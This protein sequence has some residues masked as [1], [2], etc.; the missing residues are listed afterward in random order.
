M[1]RSPLSTKRLGRG[2]WKVIR[3]WGRVR[4]EVGGGWRPHHPGPRR[5][6]AELN[7]VLIAWMALGRDWKQGVARSVLYFRRSR[8]LTLWA[9]LSSPQGPQCLHLAF[10]WQL[11]SQAPSMT[12]GRA[13]R[14]SQGPRQASCPWQLH[15]GRCPPQQIPCWAVTTGGIRPRL[16]P[17][18]TP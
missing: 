12:Y 2:K 3:R 8:R 5:P 13:G 11:R 16:A 4:G 9:P 15:S 10:L 14:G 18:Q 6:R 7:A 17:T 1:L